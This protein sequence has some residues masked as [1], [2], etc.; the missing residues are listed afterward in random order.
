MAQVGQVD[1]GLQP[2]RTALAWSR[3]ALALFVNALL[4][5]KSGFEHDDK[6][7]LLM[8]L[9]LLLAAA[10]GMVC[11]TWRKRELARLRGLGAPPRWIMLTTL[12]ITWLAAITGVLAVS[13]HVS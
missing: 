3:T 4:A 12:G 1:P 7:V 5:L 13:G 2:Q 6:L 10:A 11:G 9:A 8:G